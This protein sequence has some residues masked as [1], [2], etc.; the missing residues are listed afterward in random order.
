MLEYHPIHAYR[1]DSREEAEEH[2]YQ[3]MQE[4]GPSPLHHSTPLYWWQEAE[5][6]LVL[7]LG[8]TRW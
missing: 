4:Q 7:E 1:L 5:V 6:V 2:L 3:Y 8:P